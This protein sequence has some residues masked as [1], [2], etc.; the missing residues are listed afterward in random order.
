[1]ILHVIVGLL[2]IIMVLLFALC[3]SKEGTR[4]QNDIEELVRQ[5]SRWAVASQ[6]DKSPM[7]ALLHAN[8][9]AGYLQA[10]ELIGTENEIDAVTN[11]ENLRKKVY[12]TQDK[13]A[14]KVLFTCPNYVGKDIDK[15][16]GRLGIHLK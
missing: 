3:K 7:I 14:Q 13:A 1:M 8:Y 15:E 9:A 5:T 12:R 10:L 6:Q 2:I 11:L 4:H 16:L